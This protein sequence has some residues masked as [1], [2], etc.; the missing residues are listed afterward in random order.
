MAVMDF[1]IF[2]YQSEM[3][4]TKMLSAVM[5]FFIFFQ[6]LLVNWNWFNLEIML[7]FQQVSSVGE[8]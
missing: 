6:F 1:Q 2:S 8:S 3:V 4:D 7:S 5:L